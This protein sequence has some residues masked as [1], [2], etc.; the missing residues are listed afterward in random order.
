ME[1]EDGELKRQRL[2]REK[3]EKLEKIRNLDAEVAV[4]EKTKYRERELRDVK[5]GRDQD[6]G[7]TPDVLE[8]PEGDSKRRKIRV[9]K[10]LYSRIGEDWGE[11]E[12]T[13][14]D[15]VT[16]ILP[17]PP[18][19][20]R[21][22]ENKGRKRNVLS[23]SVIT[24][25]FSPNPKR[26]KMD[27]FD[28]KAWSDEEG[29]LI[30]SQEYGGELGGGDVCGE[31]RASQGD[32]VDEFSLDDS[33][34][35]LAATMMD[36]VDDECARV[37]DVTVM[38]EDDLETQSKDDLRQAVVSGRM[39]EPSNGVEE[40]GHQEV[41][42]SEERDSRTGVPGT[43]RI[44]DD[45]AVEIMIPRSPNR[46]SHVLG[47]GPGTTTDLACVWEHVLIERDGHI[48]DLVDVVECDTPHNNGGLEEEGCATMSLGR[49][50]DDTRTVQDGRGEEDNVAN[51]LCQVMPSI[52]TIDR[53]RF[54]DGC[55]E[56]D[57]LDTNGPSSKTTMKD[58]MIGDLDTTSPDQ[59]KSRAGQEAYLKE[60]LPAPSSDELVTARLRDEIR[61]DVLLDSINLHSRT[62]SEED[63]IGA[64]GVTKPG[65]DEE[66]GG[67][68]DQMCDVMPAPS[69]G[70]GSSAHTA[71]Q[72]SIPASQLSQ[73]T[74]QDST[75]LS[76]DAILPGTSVGA[77]GGIPG[78]PRA[79]QH[80]EKGVCS[81]HG[82]GAK[83]VWRPVP[84]KRPAPGGKKT[85][86]E[87]YWRCEMNVKGKMMTQTKISFGMKGNNVDRGNNKDIGKNN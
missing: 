14:G 26:R 47:D 77:V 69:V 67:R 52:G 1:E 33:W 13:D 30:A 27:R 22:G 29:F 59:E 20:R 34:E 19:I 81:L 62:G 73:R 79:C 10:L 70:Q 41:T 18:V 36:G 6:P 57:L 66:V 35:E 72:H 42:R 85:R 37:E 61:K 44:Q 83:W 87:H 8:R 3:Q 68:G 71:I 84:V 60:G 65:G 24:D 63:E 32:V 15:Q 86:K 38:N 74:G 43:R 45:L 54:R 40:P 25:F 16:F 12:E 4:W 56:D 82:P 28:E 50:Q 5:R 7:G 53:T 9:K 64:H 55:E 11:K 78:S 23:S 75:E 76:N 49:S 48:A 2:D 17:P 31:E 21:G 51:D 46:T 58:E 39:T 80:D